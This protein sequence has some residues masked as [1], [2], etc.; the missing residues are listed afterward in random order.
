MARAS[1][2]RLAPVVVLAVCVTARADRNDFTLERLIGA[3][4]ARG[5]FNDPTDVTRQTLYRSLMSEMG[6]VLAPKLLSPADTLGY[7]GFQIS[8]DSS[9]TQVNRSAD[10]WQ[11]GVEHVSSTYLPTISVMAR[12]GIWLPAPGFELGVGGTKLLDSHLYTLQAYAKFALLEGYH[13]WPIPSIAFRASGAHVLGTSQV[14]MTLLSLDATL[15]KS[16]GLGGV[17]KLDPYLGANSLLNF[18]GSQVIDTTP[19]VDAFA[20]GPNSTDVNSNTKFP[21]PD[22]I[23]RWR[24]FTGFRLVYSI[25]ALTGEFAYTL[26]NDSGSHCTAADPTRIVDRSGGQAQLSISGSLIF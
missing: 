11:R 7:S 19:N 14:S 24:L 1:A 6:L 23:V 26:C 9:F 12:K 4:S 10:Y 3:P 15:S 2:I 22:V 20:Q 8:F 17:V 21:N 13:H 16:F 5:S 18:I 25:F